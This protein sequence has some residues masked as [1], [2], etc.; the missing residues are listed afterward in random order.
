MDNIKSYLKNIF[1]HSNVIF[2]F[3]ILL[4]LTGSTFI[5][6]YLGEIRA[7]I[8]VTLGVVAAALTD[9]D[10]RP[11]KKIQYI[12]YT[13]CAFALVSAAVQFLFPFP[14]LFLLGL[15]FISFCLTM[16][17]IFGRQFGVVASGTL[18]IAAYT[19]LSQNLFEVE[20]T[21]TKYLVIGASWYFLLSFCEL[22]L[23][24]N[25]VLEAS[26]SNSFF[27]AARFLD[28]KAL[29]FDP[30]ET[31][32]FSRQFELASKQN[33]QF[34]KQLNQTRFLLFD[35]LNQHHQNKSFQKCLNY[36][37]LLQDIHERINANYV[38]YEALSQKFKHSDVLFRFARILNLQAKE[39]MKL[40]FAIKYRLKYEYDSTLD[41]YFN[42]LHTSLSVQQ[43]DYRLAQTLFELLANL[44][45]I[46]WLFSHINHEQILKAQYQEKEILGDPIKGL[47]DVWSRIKQ[48]FT[49]KSSLF[50]HSIRMSLVFAIGYITIQLTHIPHGYWIIL[51]SL[52]VC[53]P[54]YATTKH[55]LLLRVIGTIGGIIIG[56]P[57]I[58]VLSTLFAQ[59]IL[60][61]ISGWLFFIFKNSQY[62]YA[63]VFITL[64]VFFSF[65]LIGESSLVVAK[66]RLISTLIGC[67]IAF[68]SV[69]FIWPDWNFRNIPLA[70][71]QCYEDNSHYLSLIG[72]QYHSGKSNDANYRLIRRKIHDDN[73]DLSLL[74]NIMRKEPNFDHNYANLTYRFMIL[75]YTFISYL[76]TL[77]SHR[78]TSISSKTLSIFDNI[79]LYVIDVFHSNWDEKS[80][81]IQQNLVEESLQEIKQ[82]SSQ[83]LLVLQQL[84]LILELLPEFIQTS[85]KLQSL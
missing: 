63:T 21:L 69:N 42:Y 85:Q 72:A 66:W 67:F 53:Q 17:G 1:Y 58:F 39:C 80:H 12:F 60:I 48:N 38:Y 27:E 47:T 30:D 83:D 36:Y 7:I 23:Q 19:M 15:V 2:S 31:N 33:D 16:A 46:N 41:D 5:P 57:L 68:L 25:R 32:F 49:V 24:P 44:K 65:G 75:N 55:R 4:S 45:H 8:P 71:K 70:I 18:L 43:I 11:F 74:L 3:R 26:I 79:S 76:S 6:W 28:V 40:S 81:R 59:L 9:V 22:L 50:R 56:I 54:N 84:M 77:S 13:L 52:F 29:F 51:T 82:T 61:I 20:Y 34:I 37:F 78:D 64:L 35:H 73:S 62:A 10:V 14:Y